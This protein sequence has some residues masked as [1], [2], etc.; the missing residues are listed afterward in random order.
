MKL[1]ESGNKNKQQQQSKREPFS[2][3]SVSKM[4]DKG[5]QLKL[6]NNKRDDRC[7]T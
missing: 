5:N 6:R 7:R 4:L 2:I 3:V 1:Q